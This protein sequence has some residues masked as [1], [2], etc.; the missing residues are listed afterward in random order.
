MAKIE[1]RPMA[2]FRAAILLFVF[3]LSAPV[4]AQERTPLQHRIEDRLRDAGPGIRFGLVVATESGREI[5]SINPDG[6][7]IPA[8]NTKIFTTAAAF[9]TLTSLDRPDPSGGTGVRLERDRRGGVNVVLEGR[10]DARLSSAADC[11]TDCLVTLAD[12]VAAKTRRVRDIIGDDGF[13]PDERWSPGMSWNNI[14]TRSGTAA[15]A[16]TVDDNEVPMT[17]TPASTG[18]PPR[19]EMAPYFTIENDAATTAGGATDLNFERAP[20]SMTVRL[21]GT[22]AAGA[23]PAR[24]QLGIDD[25]AHY[26]AWLFRRMLMARGVRMT[27]AVAARH[28]PLLPAGS[29]MAGNSAVIARPAAPDALARLTPPPLGEDLILINKVSQNLHAELMLRRIGT[30]GGTGS[31]ADGLVA[32]RAMLARAGVPPSA[33]EVSDGGGMSTY[34]RVAP[35]GVVTLLRWVSAQPWGAKW[36]ATLPVG[37]EGMLTRRFAGTPLDHRVFAKTGT[38]NATSALSGYL[39]ASSGKTLVFSAYANDVPEGADG[40]SAIDAVLQMIAAEN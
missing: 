39:I 15:S 2:A 8:S 37:G 26:A 31:I 10:G 29:P 17:V 23:A 22:I 9:A 40:A 21:T 7:F 35:R 19:V 3:V 16:L 20:G 33:C 32:V 27:G 4:A 13:F 28:R 14:G 38:L 25:P 30:T 1:V 11:P 12:A 34:N 24:L 5:V 6:R 36:R 18:Q